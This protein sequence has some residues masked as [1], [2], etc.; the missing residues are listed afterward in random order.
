MDREFIDLIGDYLAGRKSTTDCREWLA[1][2]DW[3]A[4]DLSAEDKEVLGLLELLAIEVLEG[5]RPEVEFRQEA[6]DV[7][8]GLPSALRIGEVPA[9]GV[10][11][12]IVYSSTVQPTIPISLVPAPA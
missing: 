11:T 9:T 10:R 8:A 6:A 3:Y 12:R 2:I 7:V 4:P 5:M 1:G